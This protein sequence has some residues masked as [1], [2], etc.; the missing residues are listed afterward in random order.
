MDNNKKIALSLLLSLLSSILFFLTYFFYH[1]RSTISL[2]F[3]GRVNT[4][5]LLCGIFLGVAFLAAGAGIIWLVETTDL[6]EREES[7]HNYTSDAKDIE[8]GQAVQKQIKEDINLGRRRFIIGFFSISFLSLF[9]ALVSPIRSLFSGSFKKNSPGK[10]LWKQGTLVVDAS[11]HKPVYASSIGYGSLTF[12]EPQGNVDRSGVA[13]SSALLVKI[14]EEQLTSETRQYAVDGILAYSK[15][16]THVGCPVGL[17]ERESEKILCPCHQSTFNLRD[18]GKV[19]FGPAAR[20]LPILPLR[21]NS[22]GYLEAADRMVGY[23]GP[24][25]WKCTREYESNQTH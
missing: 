14:P 23:T 11:S 4:I 18:M 17:Y 1:G 21:I 13:S 7:R 3:I 12:I 25:C 5:T 8:E 10:N 16:C 24:T 22:N 15:I 9:V 19:V 6:S 2:G 20:P